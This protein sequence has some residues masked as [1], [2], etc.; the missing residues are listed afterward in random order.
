[1]KFKNT[2]IALL[3]TFCEIFAKHPTKRVL[4]VCAT[5]DCVVKAPILHGSIIWYVEQSTCV[6]CI[7]SFE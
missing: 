6:I 4:W 1:M 5:S 2:L 7:L 3:S